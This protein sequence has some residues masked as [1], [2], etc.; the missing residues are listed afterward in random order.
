MFA[1]ARAIIGWL[2]RIFP[3]ANPAPPSGP[4]NYPG[5]DANTELLQ[6]IYHGP[7]PARNGGV[8]GDKIDLAWDRKP[9][10]GGGLW[11]RAEIVAALLDR[12]AKKPTVAG[13]CKVWL[14]NTNL[15][16]ASCLAAL[17]TPKGYADASG[18]QAWAGLHQGS[19]YQDQAAPSPDNARWHAPRQTGA[20]LPAGT[21]YD[22]QLVDFHAP[23]GGVTRRGWNQ[24]HKD[25]G[26]VWGWDPKDNGQTNGEIGA[27]LGFP[28]SEDGAD[29]IIW[30]TKRE[31][32]LEAVKTVDGVRRRISVGL[33]GV[34][35]WTITP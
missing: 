5:D 18:W 4:D 30:F 22:F 21:P 33:R 32:F 16:P 12:Y 8:S 29:A 15:T 2:K 1:W 9:G 14:W 6:D 23:S 11:T 26:Y 31:V 24:S 25:V 35:Q 17:T 13:S 7:K 19:W 34:G 28:F 27:H 20:H 10:P 3:Q